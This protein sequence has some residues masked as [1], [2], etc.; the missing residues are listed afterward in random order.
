MPEKRDRRHNFLIRMILCILV[1]KAECPRK[2]ARCP[3]HQTLLFPVFPAENQ[4]SV[5]R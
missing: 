3:G 2:D 4:R 1:R 5:H